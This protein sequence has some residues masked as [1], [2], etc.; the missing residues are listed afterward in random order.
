[1]KMFDTLRAYFSTSTPDD[2]RNFGWR[3][4]EAL[5][6]RPVWA[7]YIFDVRLGFK[8]QGKWRCYFDFFGPVTQNFWNGVFTINVYIVASKWFVFPRINVVS[9]FTSTHWF[10]FGLGWLFDRGEFGGKLVIMNQAGEKEF[11]PGD[12]QGWDEGSV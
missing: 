1:M 12:A 5:A 9:R 2:R 3:L 10:Q 11:S 6:F 4:T 7:F 8:R